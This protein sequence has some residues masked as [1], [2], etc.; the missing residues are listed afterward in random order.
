MPIPSYRTVCSLPS[1]ALSRCTGCRDTLICPP[2]FPS[3][4]AWTA[5][6]KNFVLASVTALAAA[7]L[8]QRGS[9]TCMQRGCRR[10]FLLQ[11]AAGTT[12]LRSTH[13]M[14]VV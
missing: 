8:L 1:I 13:A 4:S 5:Q 6:L 7:V 10:V 3:K 2:P 14:P 11:S 12:F 9:S